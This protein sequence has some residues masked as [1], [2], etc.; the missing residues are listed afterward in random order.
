MR[1]IGL[2]PAVVRVHKLNV[3]PA[4]FQMINKLSER[5]GNSVDLGEVRFR[6]QSD[7]HLSFPGAF[8]RQ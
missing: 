5:P 1:I 8:V 6:D 3:V 4:A 2:H 7:A